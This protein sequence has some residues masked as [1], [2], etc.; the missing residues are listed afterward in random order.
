MFVS[1]AMVITE[2]QPIRT[3]MQV[4]VFACSA[5]EHPHAECGVRVARP[6]VVVRQFSSRQAA[7]SRMAELAGDAWDAWE[8]RAGANRTQDEGGSR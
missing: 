2:R 6:D 3:D 8:K 7:M 1:F 4:E 5:G